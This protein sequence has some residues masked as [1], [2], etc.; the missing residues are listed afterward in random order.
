MSTVRIVDG[1]AHVAST[2]YIPRQFFAGVA[3]NIVAP[4]VK[5]AARSPSAAQVQKLLEAQTQDHNADQLVREMDAAGV[6]ATVLLVPDFSHALECS[7]SILE[8]AAHHHQIRQRHPGRFYV[9]QG[10]DPRSGREAIDFFERTLV[11]YQFNG[12]KLYPPCGY[13]PSDERLYP[14]YE[15]CRQHGVPVLLHTGPTSPV[16]EFSW[17]HPLLVDRAAKD[18][19]GVNFILAHGGVSHTQ[20]AM[21]LCAFRPNVYLDIAGFPAALHPQ[22]WK[23]Q[24]HD[25]FRVGIN[26]KIIFGTDWPLFQ[27]SLSTR[28]SVEQLG[29]GDGPLAGL[30]QRDIECI[31]AGNIERLIPRSAAAP[32]AARD[33][34]AASR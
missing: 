28:N 26:H 4:A 1:H 31:L 24:L 11:E 20:D 27:L 30:P 32:H 14:A 7:M 22:G 29:S 17:A 10:I 33:V 19:P 13:S 12:L 34:K 3:D 23:R 5:T 8:M 6:A 21:Q 25:L 9:F 2:N 18:F 16:L 15:I